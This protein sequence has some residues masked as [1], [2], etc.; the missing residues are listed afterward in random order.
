MSMLASLFPPEPPL[1]PMNF[2]RQPVMPRY[3]GGGLVALLVGFA[4]GFLLW[5]QQQGH[6]APWESYTDWRILHGRVQIF[7]FTGSFL[8]GFA[9]QAGPH[10]V[11]GSPPPSATALALIYPLWL[12][13]FLTLVP[14]E[15]LSWLGNG[16]ISATYLMAAWLFFQIA[17]G[18]DTTR[19]AGIGLPMA[20][21][22][23]F[24]ALGAWFPVGET[25][26]ALW[27][28]W[29]GP[30]AIVFGASQQLLANVMG[31]QRLVGWQGK[32]FLGML[33]LSCLLSFLAAYQPELTLWMGMSWLVVWFWFVLHTRALLVMKQQGFNSLAVAL[34]SG[35]FFVLLACLVLISQKTA[36]LDMAVHL[37]GAGTLT[38]LILGVAARVASFFSAGRL[39]HDRLLALLLL[40]W[41][42]VALAR[43]LGWPL[44]LVMTHLGGVLLA[45]WSI[46]FFMRLHAISLLVPKQFGGRFIKIQ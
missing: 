12:G 16:A 30:L 28:I 46:R 24:L 33:L 21:G 27:V 9:L 8:L 37:L 34:A 29:C 39:F 7:L 26:H 23:F 14:F 43:S 44:S 18:G 36:G 6:L 19:L 13:F 2:T 42:G 22:F 20:L 15:P 38:V 25:S 10:V 3:W 5:L 41:D 1:A 32:V 31:G 40:A 4:L 45:W 11:A 35:F 17:R